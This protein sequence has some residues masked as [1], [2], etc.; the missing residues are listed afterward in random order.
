MT[1]WS[2]ALFGHYK[3]KFYLRDRKAG[4]VVSAHIDRPSTWDDGTLFLH[5]VEGWECR[6]EPGDII[7]VRPYDERGRWTDTERRQFLIVTLDD[8]DQEHLDGLIEFYWD[9]NTYPVISESKKKKILDSG[10]PFELLPEK[11]IKKRRFHITLDDLNDNGVDIDRMLNKELRY[12]PDI[13]PIAKIK[14]HDKM[15]D[16]YAKH[17]DGFNLLARRFIGKTD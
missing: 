16:R 17:S 6:A 2:A 3:P 1:L 9:I 12:D 8:F 5:P 7:S 15:H 4:F 11:F 13:E 10:K 14:C